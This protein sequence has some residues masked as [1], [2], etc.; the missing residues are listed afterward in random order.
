MKKYFWYILGGVA[1]IGLGYYGYKKMKAKK[2]GTTKSGN[3]VGGG[4]FPADQ[5]DTDKAGVVSNLRDNTLATVNPYYQTPIVV[6]GTQESRPNITNT[7]TSSNT[8]ST[9][10]TSP[11]G[12]AMTKPTTPSGISAIASKP[13]TKPPVAPVTEVAQPKFIGFID[14]KK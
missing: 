7:L 3:T 14:D 8:A 9:S 12:V 6:L 10:G 4:G 11:L 5:S 2:S 1:V 13:I